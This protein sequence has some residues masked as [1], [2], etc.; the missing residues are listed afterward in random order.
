MT[1]RYYRLGIL[2]LVSLLVASPVLAGKLHKAA[3]KGNLAKVERLIAKGADVNA[4]DTKFGATPL[5][6]AAENGH[7]AIAELLIANGA[8]VNA[9][10]KSGHTPLHPAATLG[11]KAIAELLIAKGAD[12]NAKGGP[13]RTPLHGAALTGQLAIAELL[14]A[15][16]ADVNAKEK[17]GTT[18]LR[19]A[20]DWGHKDLATLLTQHGAEA[21]AV[22][23]VPAQ[24]TIEQV[25]FDFDGREWR[26][27]YSIDKR[28][29][30][31][32]E[33]VLP[34]E[35]V[36]NWTEL[37]TINTFWGKQTR[38]T[39]KKTMR[40]TK[41]ITLKQCPNTTWT[42][43]NESKEEVLFEW[44]TTECP[45]FG[46]QY[47]VSKIMRGKMGIHSLAYANKKLPISADRRNR[48]INL[49]ERAKLE[50]MQQ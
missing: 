3:E 28:D 5:L 31:L 32:K 7:T 27:G 14:I 36:K 49:I 1:S 16:G 6:Y 30:T 25:R 39:P 34:G 26:E 37:V 33:F 47:E 4:K 20:T 50:F 38:M 19:L 8:N 44:Q 29:R 18:P 13:D 24:A 17:D 10:L 21:V 15:K 11:Y 40:R 12:V 9:K 48:W 42:V 46:S 23:R 35:T 45:G 22:K 41:K 2:T 43:I